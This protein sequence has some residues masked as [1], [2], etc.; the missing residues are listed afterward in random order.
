MTSYLKD[1]YD[2]GS[3]FFA[4]ESAT[5]VAGHLLGINPFDQPDVEAA[6]VLARQVVVAYQETGKLPETMPALEED[7][8][9][10]FAETTAGSIGE[11]LFE[12]LDQ[13]EQGAYVALQAYL[14]PT[15]ETN[16][17]LQELRTQIRAWTKLATTVGYGPR[18]LHSTG[19]LHK[20]D[21]GHGLFIQ[22]TAHDPQDLDIPDEAGSDQSSISFGVLKQAQALGDAQG[23]S[24]AGRKVIRFDLGQDIQAG[25]A[26]L[27]EVFL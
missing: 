27:V 22:F 11:V 14:Q 7:G 15:H 1:P 10:V 21:A 12:F 4:W 25:F 24:N 5:A 26:R 17:A 20:G 2:L 18:F 23:L 13:A 9:S 3:Q 8:I 16:N 19:Q 6:K